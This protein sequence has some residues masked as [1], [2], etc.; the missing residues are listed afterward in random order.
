MQIHDFFQIEIRGTIYGPSTLP[1]PVIN[2]YFLFI[3]TI[4]SFSALF[5]K[6]T[7][8]GLYHRYRVKTCNFCLII[9]SSL[10]TFRSSHPFRQ[11]ILYMQYKHMQTNFS[12][13]CKFPSNHFKQIAISPKQ[14]HLCPG[15]QK[16]QLYF[17]V[18]FYSIW[19]KAA[20]AHAQ[21][22]R[23]CCIP[24]GATCPRV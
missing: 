22:T 15:I 11:Y 20:A 13:Q 9:A 14:T 16:S 6:F 5:F 4:L 17:P 7:L 21:S 18:H 12:R 2:H 8:L 3:N 10:T 24:N 23:G 1:P 19:L